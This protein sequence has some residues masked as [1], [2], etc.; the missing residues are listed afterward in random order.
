MASFGSTFAFNYRPTNPFAGQSDLT[1][2]PLQNE[3][4]RD[5]KNVA[6]YAIAGVR[7]SPGASNS[8][9]RFFENWAPGQEEA[10]NA[11]IQGDPE[12][13]KALSFA[14]FLRDRMSRAT[15]DYLNSN[16]FYNQNV[17]ARPTRIIRR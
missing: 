1:R 4:F 11:Q 12:A 8:F 3:L 13:N 9:M 17:Y 5:P 7:S 6:N 10:Y 16:P 2:T 15:T 14:D